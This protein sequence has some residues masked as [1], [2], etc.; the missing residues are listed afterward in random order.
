MKHGKWAKKPCKFCGKIT[1]NI[2]FCNHECRVNF[3]QTEIYQQIDEGVYKVEPFSGNHVVRNYLV[4]RRGYKCED[5]GLSEWKQQ[6]IPLTVHHVDGDASN[7]H[8]SN[9]KLFCWNCHALTDNY[10]NK[11]EKSSRVKRYDRPLA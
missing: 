7:N 6:K 2:A 5:C 8:P 10:G 3:I 9:I 11:N 4:L 1:D